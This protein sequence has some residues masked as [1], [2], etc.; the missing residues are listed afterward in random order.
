MQR[1]RIG[2]ALIATATALIIA[3]Y[4]AWSLGTYPGSRLLEPKTTIKTKW[5]TAKLSAYITSLKVNGHDAEAKYGILAL[6]DQAITAKD[7]ELP[8][9]QLAETGDWE[10]EHLVQRQIDHNETAIIITTKGQLPT[11]TTEKT[12]IFR[13]DRPEITVHIK[14]HYKEGWSTN[15]QIILDIKNK[16]GG[17]QIDNQTVEWQLPRGGRIQARVI[18]AQPWVTIQIGPGTET[19][20][21]HLGRSDRTPAHHQ[22]GE[23]ESATIKLTIHPRRSAK[24]KKYL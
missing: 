19:Q 9:K 14:R 12:W 4:T 16:G 13:T 15:N 10:M 8:P 7:A 17:R 11:Y 18:S 21:N 20:I 2:R 22:A 5:Y 6:E 1:S 3:M 23:T 24:S